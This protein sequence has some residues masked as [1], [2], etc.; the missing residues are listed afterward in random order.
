MHDDEKTT[1]PGDGGTV[2]CEAAVGLTAAILATGIESSD[3]R[4]SQAALAIARGAGRLLLSLGLASLPEVPLPNG[5]RADVMAISPQGDIWIVE[6]KSSVE[7]FRS[8]S[9]WPDYRE[10]SDR[11]LF[12]VA[13]DFPTEILPVETGLIIADRYGGEIQ[14]TAPEHRLTAARRKSMLLRFARL[15]AL[16]QQGQSDPELKLEPIPSQL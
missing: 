2:T 15:G 16:R 12:A 11:L 4:Q 14:R 8:D 13:P 5:R 9:K 6:V 7:D 3:G 1:A 10:F